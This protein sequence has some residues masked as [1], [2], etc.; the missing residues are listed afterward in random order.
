[1][2]TL[3]ELDLSKAIGQWSISGQKLKQITLFLASGAFLFFIAELIYTIASYTLPFKA[4]P[5]ESVAVPAVSKANLESLESFENKLKTRNLFF[6]SVKIAPAAVAV[7]GIEEKVKNLSLIGIVATGEPE[8]IVKDSAL[9]Q[10]YF[11][12]RYQK[13]R[14]LEVKQ[15][16]SNSIVLKS[17]KEEKEIFLA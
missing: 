8:A 16:K 15:V 17:G 10:T 14:D 11:L 7:S 3:L 4:V 13:L 9:N 2:K 1:M 12:K 6:S 5:A